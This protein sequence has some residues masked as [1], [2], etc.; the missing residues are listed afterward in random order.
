MS[1]LEVIYTDHQLTDDEK[2]S[3]SKGDRRL[4][5]RRRVEDYFDKKALADKLKGLYYDE[6]WDDLE[7]M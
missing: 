7:A 4:L 1:E 5:A 2:T 6:Y 3:L